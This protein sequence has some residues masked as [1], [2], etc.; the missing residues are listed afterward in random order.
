MAKSIVAIVGR[1]N[2]GKSTLFNRLAGGRIAIVDD[3]PGVTRDRLY[4][5]A[6]WQ[7]RGMTIV[8]T[9]GIDLVED[10]GTII[11]QVR[12][13]AAIAMAE[14]DVI[15]FVADGQTGLTAEDEALA[16]LLRRAKKPVVVCV[17]K[18]DVFVNNFSAAEFYSLG[19]G[20]P[21]P[22]SSLHGM[23]TGDLLDAIVGRLPPAGEE[24][25]ETD[26]IRMAV[27]GR[28]NVGKSSLVNAI[29][30]QKRSIVSDIAGTTRDAID[31]PF[32]ANGQEYII[33]DTAGMRKRKNVAAGPERYSVIRALRAVDRSDVALMVLDSA[34]G[35][36]EQ[37]KKIA[38]YADE[39]GKGLILIMNKWDLVAKDSGTLNRTEKML[40]QELGFLAYAPIL[41]LSALTRQRIGKIPEL[42]SFVA[43]Q[44][45]HRVT[46]AVLNDVIGQATQLNPAPTDKGRRLK[47]FY[48]VQ[49]GVKPPHFVFFVNDPELMH[50]SYARYLENQL[51][52]NFGFEGTPIRLTTRRKDGADD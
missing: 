40:R 31:T 17:N 2:V 41:F 24:P 20:E 32:T 7:G 47:I 4:F 18:V 35:L 26:V 9:G 46:T 51:R 22:V 48:C 1:P 34:A 44:Q 45:N 10:E 28:P 12:V 23:N 11:G 3:R 8:D 27:I 43:E 49:V 15:V 50:F 5:S 30:G 38:G 21:I 52:Q 36:M 13:Q 33:I 14:A 42:V 19:F 39:A 6:E 25:P 37:D 16:I 29:I